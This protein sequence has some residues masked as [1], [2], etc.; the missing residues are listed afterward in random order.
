[1]MKLTDFIKTSTTERIQLIAGSEE[2]WIDVRSTNSE[3]FA[4]AKNQFDQAISSIL[5]TGKELV[6]EK[7]V[8]GQT[9]TEKTDDYE[10]LMSILI[11]SLIVDWSFEDEMNLCI[12]S[13][14]QLCRIELLVKLPQLLF[15]LL[16][17]LL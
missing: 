8:L 13:S 4:K 12:D 6:V 10:K 17:N 16:G 7:I 3:E 2:C 9:I 11:A 5:L 14:F 15:C 1:M